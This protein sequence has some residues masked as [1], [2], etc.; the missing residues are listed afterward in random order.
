MVPNVCL[1][2]PFSSYWLP[3]LLLLGCVVSP[4]QADKP[5]LY[6]THNVAMTTAR[7]H[8]RTGCGKPF[9]GGGKNSLHVSGLPKADMPTPGNGLRAVSTSSL[10]QRSGEARTG[11]RL[12]CVPKRPY[13][14]REGAPATGIDSF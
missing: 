1:S 5:A 9:A 4:S 10:R 6:A 14:H 3:L 12:D 13:G 11:H 2:L 7:S 8:R